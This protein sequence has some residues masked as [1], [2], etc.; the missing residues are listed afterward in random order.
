[1]LNFIKLLFSFLKCALLSQ[2]LTVTNRER[3]REPYDLFG[4]GSEEKIA[5]IRP[6]FK[7]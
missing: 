3:K 1:M 6:V 4:L 5:Y 2:Q 7:S